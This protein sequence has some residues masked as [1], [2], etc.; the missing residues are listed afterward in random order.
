MILVSIMIYVTGGAVS[1]F[2]FLYLLPIP[3][4]AIVLSSHGAVV[5]AA[6]SGMCYAVIAS[7]LIQRL[8][9]LEVSASTAEIFSMYVSLVVIALISSYIT[10]QT[11][12]FKGIV[13]LQEEHLN[14]LSNQQRQLFEDLSEGIISLDN[15][16]TITSIN[17]AA[18]KILGLDKVSNKH[19]IGEKVEPLFSRIGV[20]ENENILNRGPGSHE[21]KISN[22]GGRDRFIHYT[23]RPL[24]DSE[25]NNQGKLVVFSDISH[26]RTMEN[27]LSLHEE[28]TKLLAD[29]DEEPKGES[30]S[31][32]RV[33]GDSPVM[34]Q[35]LSLVDRVASS[36]ASV[37]ITG[38]SGTGKELISKSI[39][40]G[41]IRADKPF[42]AINCGAIPENL[43][44][45]ELFGHKKG[46]FTGAHKDQ[47]GLFRQA[48]GGTVFLDEIG[49]LPSHL[50]TKLLRVLQEKTVRAV[51][52]VHD[53]PVDVRIISATNKDLKAEISSGHFR[54]DLFYRLNVVN[55]VMPP[56]R[57]R[58]TDIPQLVRYFIGRY[59]DPSQLL[60]KISPEALELLMSYYFPGNIRELENIIERALVLG[61]QAI[62]PEHLPDEVKL[63]KADESTH[64]SISQ[65]ASGTPTQIIELPM[66]L[67]DFLSDLEKR[68][69]TQALE[70][71]GGVKKQAAELLGLNFRSFRYRLKKYGLGEANAE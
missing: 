18:S 8:D 55:I 31:S 57:D 62:L 56:L 61:G 39:H 10:R 41:S 44:E 67:E 42:I 20:Q 37:L 49:E 15:R 28:M 36:D 17:N 65:M 7:G 60:P 66:D 68:Y 50:Q 30:S 63:Y 51:G 4:A 27:R 46:S 16:G 38:E 35:V 71:S 33:I 3:V 26:L 6:F 2:L 11:E 47:P 29:E 23:V 1:P 40:L 12:S 43:I 32:S 25:G 24:E 34:K 19:I 58:R 59:A 70:M 69:L 53:Y 9:G 52:D 48:N 13:R 22:E 21:L 54:E 64:A 14:E 5:I 45:S